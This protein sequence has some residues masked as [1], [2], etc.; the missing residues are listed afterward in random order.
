M[1][2]RISIVIVNLNNLEHTK[3]CV[4]D[5]LLQDIP[6][7][8]TLID[9]NSSEVGTTEYFNDLFLKHSEGHFYGKIHILGKYNTGHNKPLNHIWNDFVK[10]SETEFIC[11]LNND[12]R[13]SPNFLSSSV[14]LF[15]MKPNVGVINHT[16]NSKDFQTWSKNLDYIIQETPYRQGWDLIFR[17]ELY[18]NIPEELRFFYGDDYLF[19]K[20]Y[21]NGYVGAYILNSPVIHYEKSTTIEKNGMRD[22]SIDYEQFKNIDIKYNN[23]HFNEEFSKWKPEFHQI[24]EDNYSKESYL[25]RDPDVDIWRE[26]LNTLILSDYKDLLTGTIAD[27]GCNHGAVTIIAAE[28]ILSQKIIGIDINLSA[29]EVANNLLLKHNIKNIEYIVSNLTNLES[30]EDNHFDNAF[31]FHTLEHIHPNDYES[32]F[33]EIKRTIK[34]EGH[35]IFSIPYEHAYDDPTHMNY[36]N[37][38]SLSNLI[39]YN[40][41]KV[42]ECYRDTRI[43]F[44]CLNLVAKIIK[45]TSTQ[46]SILICSLLERNNTF[47]SKLLDNINQQIENKP[48]EVLILSDNANRPVGTKRNN[49]LKLAKGKYVSFIDDDDRITDDYVDSIL[50]EIYEWK[51]D[52]IVFDAEITFDG[53]NP[54]LVK[55]G[56]EYDYC[57]K[58]EAYYRHPNHLMVHKKE[59]ITEYFKDIKTGEDDEWALRMLPRIVTQS[60]INKILYYYDFNTSTKK[61]FK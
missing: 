35:I 19:S 7:N 61:Y 23:L 52:V 16:T 46:L 48:V 42:I 22:S 37:E 11:F 32:F 40:G 49:L 44:D 38:T 29:I 53:Y 45:N 2:P 12:V 33:N 1:T 17:R 27:F 54:K 39:T 25:T 18:C 55:Y 13:L 14:L 21:E 26:H 47:L 57:E 41:L 28:N 34:N 5:L 6:F 36:F 60:R 24:N 51:S 56:R 20:L 9:Q 4:N 30:I 59:N 15:D 43:G 10:N 31:S 50:N 8:L 3:N 58:P